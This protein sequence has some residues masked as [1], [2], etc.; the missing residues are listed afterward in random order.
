MTGGTMAAIGMA[1]GAVVAALVTCGLRRLRDIR[2]D[3]SPDGPYLT[4]P[5]S[6]AARALGCICDP[7]EP[8]V[9]AEGRLA[10]VVEPHCPVHGLAEM[11][12]LLAEPEPER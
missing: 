9:S 10:F 11:K 4:D 8:R 3:A 7:Q 5:G 1:V 6:A 12:A 2:R